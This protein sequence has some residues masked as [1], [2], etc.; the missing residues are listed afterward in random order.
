MRHGDSVT[1]PD[2]YYYYYYVDWGDESNEEASEGMGD[3]RERERERDTT[4]ET[5]IPKS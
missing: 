4:G 2:Y 3:E 1:K 5:Q